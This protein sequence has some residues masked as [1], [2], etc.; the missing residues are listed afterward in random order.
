[1]SCWTITYQ[2]MLS[3]MSLGVLGEYDKSLSASYLCA[4]ILQIR[5]NTFRVFGD[6]VVYRKQL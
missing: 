2:D 5:L 1:M 4:R 3:F 6:D